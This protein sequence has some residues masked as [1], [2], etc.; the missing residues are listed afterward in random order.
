MAQDEAI[1]LLAQFHRLG[2]PHTADARAVQVLLDA[3]ETRPLLQ[4]LRG[5]LGARGRLHSSAQ[6][7]VA[8]NSVGDTGADGRWRQ[9]RL[10]QLRMQ[11]A[12]L[13]REQAALARRLPQLNGAAHAATCVGVE[14]EDTAATA[15][16]AALGGAL[17]AAAV[18]V[19]RLRLLSEQKR[20]QQ[21]RRSCTAQLPAVR[22][23]R[24]GLCLG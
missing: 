18:S 17:N 3:P 11:N 23:V 20:V 22:R 9:R 24:E 4:R 8:D 1:D 13:R 14:E 7:A 15:A 21:L 5:V 10:A 19:A 12:L 6:T 2:C 16:A